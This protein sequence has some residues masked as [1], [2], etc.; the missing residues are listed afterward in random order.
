[1]KLTKLDAIAMTFSVLLV[2][3]SFQICIFLYDIHTLS[4]VLSL[5]T[6]IVVVTFKTFVPEKKIPRI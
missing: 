5:N 1:M 4:F 2:T 6:P 3:I